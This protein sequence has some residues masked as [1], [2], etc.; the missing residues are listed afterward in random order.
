MKRVAILLA[1]LL[2][3][4]GSQ[5]LAG[6]ITWTDSVVASGYISLPGGGLLNFTDANVLVSI[7]GFT[8]N[9]IDNG[10]GGIP[11]WVDPFDNHAQLLI[12]GMNFQLTTTFIDS[13]IA[14]DSWRGS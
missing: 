11:Y 3:L 1:L 14:F 8:Y 10:G 9:V 4:A 5:A 12:Q 6:D 13:V 2:L 7:V